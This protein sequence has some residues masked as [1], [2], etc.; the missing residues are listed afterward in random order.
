M[1]EQPEPPVDEPLN[2]WCATCQLFVDDDH[3]HQT[4]HA[5]TAG[6]PRSLEKKT[7]YFT[8][9]QA[10]RHELR[11]GIVLDKDCVVSITAPD[12]KEVMFDTFGDHW[13]LEYPTL[14]DMSFYPRGIYVFKHGTFIKE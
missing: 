8:F 1:N 10:H 2:W 12:P 7:H 5:L 4:M 6:R 3:G 11:S 9:G 14:P 13:S